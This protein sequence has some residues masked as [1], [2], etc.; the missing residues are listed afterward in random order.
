M[1]KKSKIIPQL[2]T[3]DIAWSTILIVMKMPHF[4]RDQEVNACVKILLSF[5]HGDYLWLDRHINI[6]TVLIHQIT[7]LRMQGPDPHDFYPVKE[8]LAKQEVEVT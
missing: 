5:F 7:R 6:D 1:W 3:M 4:G 8:A 2:W